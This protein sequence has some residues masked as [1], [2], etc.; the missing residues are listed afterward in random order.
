MTSSRKPKGDS[1]KIRLDTNAA[2]AT[3]PK[4]LGNIIDSSVDEING[5]K[6]GFEKVDGVAAD[7]ALCG[8]AVRLYRISKGY[9]RRQVADR[10]GYS[11]AYIRKIE[12]GERTPA[13]DALNAICNAL[14]ISPSDLQKLASANDQRQRLR[15]LVFEL[16][17][18]LESMGV[19]TLRSLFS[20]SRKG[21]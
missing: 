15:S 18:L 3:R 8:A 13:N 7:P 2:A 19:A 16:D 5:P 12:E 21:R 10:S 20:P 11:E 4:S 14:G 17:S 6:G 9:S 1:G